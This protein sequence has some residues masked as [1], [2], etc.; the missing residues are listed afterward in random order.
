MTKPPNAR[1]RAPSTLMLAM[2]PLWAA[3]SVGLEATTPGKDTGGAADTSDGQGGDADGGPPDTGFT[4]GADGSTD[5]SADGSADGAADGGT[6]GGGSGGADDTAGDGGGSG[7]ADG[8][9]DG[10]AAVEITVDVPTPDYGINAGGDRVTIRGGPFDASAAV[11]FGTEL[12]T[13]LSW[14]ATELQV[15]T[16]ANAR[17]GR[18]QVAVATDSG[19]GVRPGAFTYWPDGRGLVGLIG[20]MEWGQLVGGYWGGSTFSEGSA[21]VYFL[22]PVSTAWWSNFAP[23]LDSCA[24]ETY[25]PPTL[26]VDSPIAAQVELRSTSGRSVPLDWDATANGYQDTALSLSQW[27]TGERYSLQPIPG[28]RVP[29][30]AIADAL[31]LPTTLTVT[32]PAITGSTA[33][34]FSRGEAVTWAA[35]GNDWVLIRLVLDNGYGAS[36]LETVNCVARDDGSFVP[37]TSLFSSW[38]VGVQLTLNV[39]AARD[40]A[41]GQVPWN[42]S[43][44]KVA[45]LN[46]V[47]GAV[48]TR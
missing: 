13:V 37:D 47:I 3:C 32:N 35:G 2:V 30:V 31:T 15:S 41:G 19:A 21:A 48:F 38:P 11:S 12:G 42:Q 27:G 22:D 26:Y 6:G 24:H 5:G 20:V 9:A 34:T 10:A 44:S 28:D 40:S 25:T 33:D 4:G 29:E 7:D 43:S 18:V 36:G 17:V 14:T 8:G 23:S 39:S 1:L 16:P 46:T 45:G